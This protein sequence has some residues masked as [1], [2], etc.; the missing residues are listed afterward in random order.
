MEIMENEQVVDQGAESVLPENGQDIVDAEE[1]NLGQPQDD[2]NPDSFALNYKGQTIIPKDR[3][4][5]INLA[6]QGHGYSQRMEELNKREKE[7]ETLG[8]SYSRYE[9]L[10]K[11]FQENP[12]LAQ[13][14]QNVVQRYQQGLV[15]Q[16]GEE[17]DPQLVE[18]RQKTEELE[19]F[20]QETQARMADQQLQSEVKSLREANPDFP[21]DV[22]DGSGTLEQKVLKHAFDTQSPSLTMA[23]RDMMWDNHTLN[24]RAKGAKQVQANRQKQLSS[25]VV[26]R[27]S[28]PPPPQNNSF[29]PND[30]YADLAGKAKREFGIT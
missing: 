19:R 29:N 24:Q 23:F 11:A 9:G 8:Q 12:A 21:W 26:Q 22:D 5:L 13:E 1:G 15:G 2:F 6:Q 7:L 18:I 25:G 30:S 16:D 3:Q 27:T 14:I 28:T 20:K 4:H 10:D 17:L